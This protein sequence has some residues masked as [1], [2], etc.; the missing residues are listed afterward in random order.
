MAKN[1][2]NSLLVTAT[3]IVG[4]AVFAT[5]VGLVTRIRYKGENPRAELESLVSKVQNVAFKSDVFDNSTTYKQIKALLFD[6]TGKLRPGIDLN[7]FISFYT[8]VNSKIQK[9]EVS[10]APNKPFF[11][12]INLI[13]DDKNQTFTLQ[14]RAK[15]QLD[16]NYTA[17]SSILSKKIAYAQRSQFALADF[18][19]NHRKIT[20][21]FQTNIQNLRETDFSVDFSS[22]QTSLAS[23]KI[24]FLTRVEDFAADI[25]KSGNQEEAISRISKYFPDFQRYIHELKDDPNNV[26]P[27]KKGKIFDFSITR[28]AGTNDFISLSANSE[29]SFLIKARLT[30]EAKFE[31][32]G[33]N[34][35]EAEML[36]EIKLVPVDQ[37]VV[38]LE[39]DLKP[40]QAPE[41]SQKP[42]SEQTE[43]KKTYFAEIDKILSKITM[44]KLQLSDFKVAPQTSSSQPKQVKASVS[45]GSNLDQGQENRILV[46]VSQ[47]SSNPQQQQQPQPQSQPQPQPQSQPQ[48][49]PQPNAQTQPKAQIQSSPKAPVQKPATPD[50]SKSFKI[51]TKRA[52]DFLKEFNKTFYRSNKLKSQ[53]LEEKINSEY[54]SNK[55]GIDLGVLK[56]YISNNQGIEY[57]FDIANAKIRDAQDGITS[58]IEI[59]VTISLWSSFF[60]DSDNV[61]LKSK[62]ETF[63]IPYFQKETTSESKDQK[64]GHTQ[65][66]LD[67]NQKLVYQLSELPGTSTQGSSGSSTQTEQIKEVKL[68]TLTAFISKQELEALIDGDKNLASQ[69]VSQTVSVSQEVKATEFQQQEA[70]STNSSPTSPSPSPTSPSPASPSS[71]PSPTSPKNVDENIGVPNPRFE[72]IKKIISS[73]FTYKY[74]FRAN[75]AL[76]DAWVGKQNFP[77]LKDISQFRSDQ[78]LAKDYKLVNLK[79]NKFLKEDYDV[80]AFYAN[81]VQKDPREVLQYLFE[82]AKANN[83]IGPEEKLDLNQ[84]DDDGIFRR[85]KAIKLIDK[86][87]NNQGIYGFSFNNQFLKF[88][89]RGWM[90]TLYLPNEAKTKLADY[91]NLL[92]AG[93]SD[94]KIFSELNKIQ[95]LDLKVQSSDSSDSKSDS[96]DSSDSKT[97]PTNQDLLSKLTSL[98]SQIEAIVKK[99]ETESKKY[100][101]TENN[102]G[103]GSS[104]TEQKGSSIPEENKKFIL[105]NTAKLDNLADLLLAFYYQA[106]RLNFASWSQLQDEDLDYQIQ[107]EKEA[108]NTESSSSSSSSSSL[109]SSSSSSSETDTNKP[110]NA[111]EYKLTYYYKIYNKTTKKVVYTTPKTIIKLYLASSNIGVKEKQ[112]RELMNKLV[113]SIPSAYSIFYLKQNEWD[114]VKTTNNGQQMGQP[115]SSQGFES[116][117]PFKKIQEIVH[118]NN[119]DYDLKVVTI[120]DDAYAENAKIVHLRVVRKEEQQGEQ[121]EKGKE[122]EKEKE[123][124]P[125]GQVPQSAF[126]FQV[127]LIKDDYQGAEASNQQT[128]KQEMQMPNMENQN[129]GSSSSAPAAAAAKAAK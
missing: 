127:R 40:G 14:F 15:H 11:E 58:H 116:L 95:P 42:Q 18:N 43:I 105:E 60:G 1:N 37:F 62:T 8:A 36:E 63:I 72:E 106:K 19:A 67:L 61:L 124:S 22:S 123:K 49:Q 89:E 92:S 48:S 53:K 56:K 41:K 110:E 20:K 30:N 90:S 29:P 86:S 100:L 108:N 47:Q 21:S 33:L 94:T 97:T 96:S 122:K 7:K 39:T 23:Q 32:R 112:E 126:F 46:P 10:F 98:K 114:Q 85:A 88:H 129:S 2:K 74:N 50:P 24:P 83:L 81:L 68:P 78:R 109:S 69:P 59:P 31:L 111:V 35:E 71:S 25:N 99:Y 121:K 9:F 70:N 113:L 64:V 93:I 117:E 76:L 125:Q 66:E 102:N 12:F 38:N 44:R 26:L 16:N 34:I 91:Q 119:K 120:R 79:S 28:R 3:A 104:G 84:I 13:P 77:S 87:S 107:F 27:F 6:E 128:S 45:A 51:R 17:Y 103:G 65:K 57:T 118:K 101:G 73:E 55:I 75:E 5:T 54:L 80:L 82:I 52:R 115:S 4:V